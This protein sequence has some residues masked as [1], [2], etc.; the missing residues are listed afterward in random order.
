MGKYSNVISICGAGRNVGK[1]YLGESIIS[2]F[3]LQNTVIAIKISKFKHKAIDK[4]GLQKFFETPNFAI[5][6][7]LNFTHKDSGRYLK[8]GAKASYYIECDDANLL[9]A[10]LVIYKIYK[11][12]CL[13]ICESA[14][15][16]KYINP[17][18]SIFVESESHI[19]E[20]NKLNCLNRSTLVLKEKSIEISMPQL[21][22]L[23]QNNNWTV[24]YSQKILCD[25]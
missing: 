19:T 24:K 20:S 17:A 23:A 1:T 8:A 5:W 14:S 2:H 12:S 11:Q 7:E 10:F 16:S 13:L 22:L 6:E 9:N 21:F 15:I 4:V 3:S 18:V 25:A